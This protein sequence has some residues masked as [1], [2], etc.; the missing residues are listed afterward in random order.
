MVEGQEK[1]RGYIK[2]KKKKKKKGN[3][4][5]RDIKIDQSKHVDRN[6]DRETEG[7]ET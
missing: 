1:E 5:K 7:K 6:R 3:V 2:T 4:R